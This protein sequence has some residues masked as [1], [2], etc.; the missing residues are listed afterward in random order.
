ME[1]RH[2]DDAPHWVARIIERLDS[3]HTHVQKI[4][5]NQVKEDKVLASIL[6][7]VTP[8]PP[9]PATSLKLSAGPVEEQ[10]KK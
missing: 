4:E 6:E 8:K 3:I 1:H 9:Q 2:D 7:L 10:P 5:H